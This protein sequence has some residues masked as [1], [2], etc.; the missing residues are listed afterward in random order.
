L[1]NMKYGVIIRNCCDLRAAPKFRSERKSQ[2]LYNDTVAVG[3]GRNSY[4]R[5]TRSDGY[6]GWVDER[7][8]IPIPEKIYRQIRKARNRRVI[9]KT[10]SI[11][12]SDKSARGTHPPF[13]FYGTGLHISR[14]SNGRGYFRTPDGRPASIPAVNIASLPGRK[15]TGPDGSLIVREARK[16][17]GVPYLW[18]GITPFGFDCSGLVQMIYG[19][20]GIVLPRDSLDQRK[21]VRKID[22]EEV[23][24]GDLLFFKGHVAIAVDK[25]RIIHA[26]LGEGGVAEN[27]LDPDTVDFRRDLHE[28]F[29]S[30][31]RVLL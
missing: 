31:G 9:S 23:R 13:L 4:L 26:S 15:N 3:A 25:R 6:N 30:A 18:G 2:L 21:A 12:L 28:T 1:Y 16:F 27:S 10:S 11:T 19:R 17:L 24:S 20:F 22:R 8:L 7:A 14:V 5:V 29:I